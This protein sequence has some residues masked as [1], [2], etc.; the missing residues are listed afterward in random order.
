MILSPA[1]RI[2]STLYATQLNSGYLEFLQYTNRNDITQA[3]LEDFLS[4]EP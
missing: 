4:A 1:N 3:Y 2:S